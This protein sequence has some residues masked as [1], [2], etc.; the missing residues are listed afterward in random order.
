M[1]VGVSTTPGVAPTATSVGQ[2]LAYTWAA[3]SGFRYVPGPEFST[4]RW[5]N[6]WIDPDVADD[7]L[8]RAIDHVRANSVRQNSAGNLHLLR[9]HLLDLPFLRG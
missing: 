2:Q 1:V 5:L 8:L 3:G 7:T 6:L 4:G 9:R